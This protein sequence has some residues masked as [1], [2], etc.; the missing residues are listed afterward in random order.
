MC[1]LSLFYISRV[2]LRGAKLN[3]YIQILCSISSVTLKKKNQPNFKTFYFSDYPME[4][5][6]FL[7]LIFYTMH[8]KVSMGGGLY[9]H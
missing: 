2:N 5:R 7:I 3:L 6:I 1:T 9:V 8:F 4:F